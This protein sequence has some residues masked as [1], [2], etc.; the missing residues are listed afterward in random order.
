MISADVQVGQ[1]GP[2]AAD[3]GGGIDAEPG[4]YLVVD[5]FGG[6]GEG[7]LGNKQAK[8]GFSGPGT[9]SYRKTSQGQ[10]GRLMQVNLER[11]KNM[12]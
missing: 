10:A 11:R 9:V 5:L 6:L 2:M 1:Q 8:T 3:P 12:I 4:L 7:D